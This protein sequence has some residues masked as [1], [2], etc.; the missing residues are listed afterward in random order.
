[1]RQHLDYE[2]WY[3]LT[4]LTRKNIADCQYVAA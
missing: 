3:D 2:H 1:M 4:K